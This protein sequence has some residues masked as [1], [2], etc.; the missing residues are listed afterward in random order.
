M[1]SATSCNSNLVMDNTSLWHRRLGHPCFQRLVLLQ[2]VIPEINTC[3][4]NKSYDCFICPVAK[5][6]RLPLTSSAHSS[7]SCFDLVHVD[8]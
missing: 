5:Q 8:I 4:N 3:N 6:K 7:I 1:N 2:S